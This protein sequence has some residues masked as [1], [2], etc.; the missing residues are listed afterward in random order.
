M[1]LLALAGVEPG[2][3]AADYALSA[4]RL[5]SLYAAQ[6]REDENAVLETFLRERDTTAEGAIVETLH[7]VDVERELLGGG[8]APDD[9][10][11]LR[12]RLV[13]TSAPAERSA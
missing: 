5:S 13:D 4:E 12:A 8:L 3:I 9:I 1:V 2:E 7:S 10:G 11:A 6:G